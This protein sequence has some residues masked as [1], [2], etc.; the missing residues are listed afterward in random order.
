MRAGK[1]SSPPCTGYPRKTSE[2]VTLFPN[3]ASFDRIG[4]TGPL[5]S[6][7]SAVQHLSVELV[8][9]GIPSLLI[10]ECLINN[11]ISRLV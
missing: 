9:D 10:T 8:T 5:G 7:E 4:S 1:D 6:L 11:Q 2:E 3:V